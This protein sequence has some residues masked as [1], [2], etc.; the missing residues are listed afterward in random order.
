MRVDRSPR[1]PSFRSIHSLTAAEL[2]KIVLEADR[3]FR[4]WT[5]QNVVRH[6]SERLVPIARLTSI[7]CF[8][9]PVPGE[10]YVIAYSTEVGLMCIDAEAGTC[11]W[12]GQTASLHLQRR[13][14]T[15]LYVS[16]QMHLPGCLLVC[17]CMSTDLQ[18]LC[19]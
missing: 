4:I 17:I 7:P 18:C 15:D 3:A 1:L 13:S 12:E 5:C 9:R 14:S 16:S 2:R 6:S 10:A 8:V 11:I 19:E